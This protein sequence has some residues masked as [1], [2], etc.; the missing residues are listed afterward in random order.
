MK[1]FDTTTNFINSAVNPG[2]YVVDDIIETQ[3]Y[4]S[5]GGDG[6]T[7]WRSTGNI[8]TASQDPITLNDIKLSDASGNEF[9]LVVEEA[10]IID[11]NVLGGTSAGFVNIANAA[12]LTFSQGLTSDI[13]D[14]IVN[15]DTVSNL[16]NKSGISDDEAFMLKDRAN[17]VFDAVLTSSVTPLPTGSTQGAD[18]IVSINN[19]LI[20]FVLR[21]EEVNVVKF[22]AVGDGVEDDDGV[23]TASSTTFTSAAALWV[24]D[25]IGKSIS[26]QGAGTAGNAHVTTIASIN[27]GQSIELTVAAVTTVASAAEYRYGTDNTASMQASA[28]YAK[29]LVDTTPA[30]EVTATAKVRIPSGTYL[31]NTI[32]SAPSVIFEGDGQANTILQHIG[33]GLT[34]II[35][36]DT[37]VDNVK[38]SFYGM[39]LKGNGVTN[40]RYGL[41]LHGCFYSNVVQDILT[42]DCQTGWQF[43]KAFTLTL[44]NS[45]TRANTFGCFWDDGNSAYIENTRFEGNTNYQLKM[46]DAKSIHMNLAIFQFAESD[47]ACILEGVTGATLTDC[48][49]EGNNKDDNSYADLNIS[50]SVA[51]I[52]GGFWTQSTLTSNT[53]GIAIKSNVAILDL[54]GVMITPLSNH[55]IGLQLNFTGAWG[56]TTISGGQLG[57]GQIDD[58]NYAGSRHDLGTGYGASADIT[59]RP[60][61]LSPLNRQG[62]IVIGNK[63]FQTV[64]THPDNRG[65]YDD[66]VLLIIDPASKTNQAPAVNDFTVKVDARIELQSNISGITKGATTTFITDADH[67]YKTGWTIDVASIVDDGPG[68]DIESTFNGNSYVITVTET[69]EFTV[70]VNSSGLTN[71]WASAGTVTRIGSQEVT[72]QYTF[73][74]PFRS[75][76]GHSFWMNGNDY[77]GSIGKPTSATDGVLIATLT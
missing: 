60:H 16:E 20:S 41:Q 76:S 51:C 63:T 10:G 7:K 11:L 13:S 68:G 71:E 49:F 22:G 19:A 62:G 52:N 72:I 5:R 65:S 42:T 25:D 26:I 56:V 30:F 18:I 47:D 73:D 66:G 23:A 3:G 4:S 21:V 61:F 69:D 74:R 53:T 50:G 43:T 1:R 15:I 9:E 39:W 29:V 14:D 38:T 31:L 40:T 2:G 36:T 6:G 75:A 44:K 8:I 37:G 55:N 58:S 34:D 48:Q 33:T 35:A 67:G 45:H 32:N 54:N 77:R 28:D 59:T 46:V 64:I 57:E 27:T 24:S 12:G 70:A 17:G